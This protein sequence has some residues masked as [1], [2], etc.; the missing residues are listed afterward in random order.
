MDPSEQLPTG[1]GYDPENEHRAEDDAL[2]AFIRWVSAHS[3]D[4]TVL[5]EASKMLE[6]GSVHAN[7]SRWYA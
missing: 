3:Y 2:W 7:R 4:R 6:W 5:D 1:T